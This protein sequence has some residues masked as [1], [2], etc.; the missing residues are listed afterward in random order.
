MFR[1]VMEACPSSADFSTFRLR[2]CTRLR[3]LG[4]FDRE[5][6]LGRAATP[7]RCSYARCNAKSDS[8]LPPGAQAFRYP[9]S[10][11]PSMSHAAPPLCP[12]CLAEFPVPHH[13]CWAMICGSRLGWGER[14]LP[15]TVSDLTAADAGEPVSREGSRRRVRVVVVSASPAVLR[16]RTATCRIH[17]HPRD[18]ALV[19]EA[20]R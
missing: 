13:A 19:G 18:V 15:L 20:L 3:R 4:V 9:L 11:W 12:A 1:T 10:L 5:V 7:G 6:R 16:S 2:C 8:F 14:G 17:V